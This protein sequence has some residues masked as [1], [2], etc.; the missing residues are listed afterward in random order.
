MVVAELL[1]VGKLV[2]SKRA[3]T[4]QVA[5]EF[6]LVHHQ[7]LLVDVRVGVVFVGQRRDHQNLSQHVV[8][9]V[10]FLPTLRTSPVTT[11]PKFRTKPL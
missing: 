8:E 9:D 4:Q 10:R 5:A 2:K 11:S 6:M 7:S 1:D 3:V